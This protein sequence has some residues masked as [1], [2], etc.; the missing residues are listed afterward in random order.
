MVTEIARFIIVG[1]GNFVLT[2]TVFTIFLKIFLVD[3]LLSLAIAWLVGIICSY[4]FNF[5]W[6]FK[7]QNT[8][9]FRSRFLK[10]SSAG[11]LS[12]ILNLLSLYVLVESTGMD[13]FVTQLILIPFVVSFNYLTSKFWS[14]R[15]SHSRPHLEDS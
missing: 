14:L 10:F 4:V 7:P 15:K 11:M 5:I 8:I 3:Y 13:P 1:V 2:F 6:V 9:E 12:I